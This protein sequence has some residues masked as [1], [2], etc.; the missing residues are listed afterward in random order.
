MKDEDNSEVNLGESQ[1]AAALQGKINLMKL[2]HV[3]KV[4]LFMFHLSLL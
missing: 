1:L 4:S 3:E 2:Q